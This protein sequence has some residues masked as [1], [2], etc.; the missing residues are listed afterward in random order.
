[1]S[2]LR[3]RAYSPYAIPNRMRPPATIHAHGPTTAAART[4]K[5]AP[6][7]QKSIGTAMNCLGGD[8]FTRRTLVG[9]QRRCP[10]PEGMSASKRAGVTPSALGHRQGQWL[11]RAAEQEEPDVVLTDFSKLELGDS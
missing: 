9:Q 1:M 11:R 10:H 6:S 3:L 7:R 4:R 2:P 8:R 5:T